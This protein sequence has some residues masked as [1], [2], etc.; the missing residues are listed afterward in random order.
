MRV[1]RGRAADIEGDRDAT[2]DLLSRAG[3]TGEPAVRTWTPHRQVAFGRRDASEPGYEAARAIARSEGFPPVERSVGGRAV[4]YTGTTLAFALALP[5]EDMR[6]GLDERY[7][8]VA[9]AVQRALW[10][11]G[12]PVR[13][14]EPADSFCPGSHS[15]RSEGKIAGIAQRV[16]QDAALV[17]GIVVVDD[18]DAI[19]R[20]LDR[21]YDALDVP[22]DPDSVGSV[23]RAGGRADSEAVAR[24][25]E[26]KLVG[27]VGD[28]EE[29]QVERID[30]G[31]RET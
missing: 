8:R 18:H 23:A 12:V 20:V 13:R 9:R 28:D 2:A 27:V 19:A 10:N 16:T 3:E 4:V 11:V 21:I 15:L 25:I 14:G 29:P 31:D 7:D 22:F 30:S 1:V 5:I 26:T 6:R 17:S 24:A